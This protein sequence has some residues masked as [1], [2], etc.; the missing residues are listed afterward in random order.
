MGLWGTGDSDML[1]YAPYCGT[2]FQVA[3][4]TQLAAA[5]DQLLLH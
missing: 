1:K 5:V 3:N 4:L 2:T